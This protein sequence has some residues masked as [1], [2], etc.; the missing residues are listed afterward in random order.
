MVGQKV[1][2]MAGQSVAPTVAHWAVWMVD[3]TV[4]PKD[5]QTAAQ[6]VLLMDNM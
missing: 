6:M 4:L 5:I 1:A 2:R 3:S